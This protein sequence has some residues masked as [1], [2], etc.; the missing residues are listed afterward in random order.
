M[1]EFILMVALGNSKCCIA[2]HYV[3]TFNSCTEAHEYVK[4]HMPEGP[5]ETR[6]LLKQYTNLPNALP[7][8]PISVSYDMGW[9][10][11]RCGKV[12][13]SLSGHAFVIGCRTGKVLRSGVL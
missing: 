10:K 12:Y 7:K 8:I 6:C 4:N 9:S 11:R 13:N 5:K 1:A 3:G 2:E